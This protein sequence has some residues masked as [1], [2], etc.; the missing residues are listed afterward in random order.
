MESFLTS[1]LGLKSPR[2]RK[3]W[4]IQW[5]PFVNIYS[6]IRNVLI[7]LWAH[8]RHTVI[9]L[10]YAHVDN[11]NSF[12]TPLGPY[13]DFEVLV[14]CLGG[15]SLLL[16]EYLSLRDKKSTDILRYS[17]MPFFWRYASVLSFLVLYL[18]SLIY[19][20]ISRSRNTIA[21]IGFSFIPSL[22]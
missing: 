15:Y 17:N 1:S 16:S 4:L 10:T 14:I 2:K 8:P 20:I 18:G 12:M 11:M 13:Y 5:S 3:L 9:P 7:L 6:W 21:S 19:K 22:I